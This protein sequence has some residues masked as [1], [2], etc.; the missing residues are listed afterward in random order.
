MKVDGRFGR[1]LGLSSGRRGAGKRGGSGDQGVEFGIGRKI[2]QGPD[3][4][5]LPHSLI[6]GLPGAK[7]TPARAFTSAFFR[8][9]KSS[10]VNRAISAT[11][12]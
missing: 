5:E 3:L 12:V 9:P 2:V 1:C 6:R 7:L 8:A 10:P 11:V 4:A